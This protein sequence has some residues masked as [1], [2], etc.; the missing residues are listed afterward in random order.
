MCDCMTDGRTYI[1]AEVYCA[2]IRNEI[3]HLGLSLEI[4]EDSRYIVS[5][6]NNL[7][8]TGSIYNQQEYVRA[9]YS[10]ISTMIEGIR[11]RIRMM[12]EELQYF[13]RY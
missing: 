2:L 10:E 8:D 11:G 1:D 13:D 7:D 6:I 12:T 5:S 3:R 4:H 9:Y